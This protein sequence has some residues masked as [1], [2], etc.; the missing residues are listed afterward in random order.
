MEFKELNVGV[1]FYFED[2]L[3]VKI[4]QYEAR[5]MDGGKF[6]FMPSAEVEAA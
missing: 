3:Y 2:S 5:S 1:S 6:I 4:T